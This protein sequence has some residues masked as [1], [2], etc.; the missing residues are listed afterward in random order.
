MLRFVIQRQADR[1]VLSFLAAFWWRGTEQR[2]DRQ[3]QQAWHSESSS[4]DLVTVSAF[5]NWKWWWKNKNNKHVAKVNFDGWWWFWIKQLSMLLHK[6]VCDRYV[7]SSYFL[8]VPQNNM[9]SLYFP[10]VPQNNISKTYLLPFS[11]QIM[12]PSP[13]C[14]GLG[15]RVSRF[16]K[17][18]VGNP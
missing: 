10:L 1:S 13:A 14:G 5:F 17:F 4:S 15:R 12:P 11:F 2:N 7:C 18:M 16:Q 6:L 9:C 8:F 3:Q